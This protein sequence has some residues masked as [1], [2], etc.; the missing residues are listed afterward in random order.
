VRPGLLVVSLATLFVA[1]AAGGAVVAPPQTI[2]SADGVLTVRVP[3]G[4]TTQPVHVRKLRASAYE[5]GPSG[6]RFAK[7]VTL[8][9]RIDATKA[10]FDLKR[11]VPGIVLASRDAR[12]R[13]ERLGNQQIRVD[14]KQLVVSGTARHLSL[15]VAGDSGL[16]V[17]LVPDSVSKQEGQSWRTTVAVS[18]ASGRKDEFALQEVRWR[19][20]NGAVKDMGGIG[21]STDTEVSHVYGCASGGAGEYGAAIEVSDETPAQIFANILAAGDE[22]AVLHVFAY[23]PARCTS[24]PPAEVPLTLEA[25]ACSSRTRRSAASRLT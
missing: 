4:A 10:G 9:W 2:V 17:S 3:A 21:S 7:P 13:W 24:A 15:F 16:R 1:H 18:S 14:G 23:Q 11:A 5:L 22:P 19:A 25:A 20:S 12:G 8:T 6:L